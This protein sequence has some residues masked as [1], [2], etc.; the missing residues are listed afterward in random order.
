MF[1]YDKQ[2]RAYHDVKVN[3][4]EAIRDKLKRHRKANQDRIIESKPDG[5]SVSRSRFIKQGSYAMWTTIQEKDNAYDIDDGLVL[6]AD[7]LV[8]GNGTD[9]TPREAK[10]MVLDAVTDPRFD[11]PPKMMPNCVRAFYAEGHH[12]DIAVYRTYDDDGETVQ[13]IAGE[14]TWRKS[15]PRRI[16]IWFQ[17][18]VEDLNATRPGSGSQLRRMV[19]LLKRF[20]KS[21]TSWDMPNG[22]KL[23]MLAAECFTCCSRD[24]EAFCFLIHGLHA[25]LT[26]SLVVEN[27]ADDEWPRARLT[28]TEQDHNMVVLR[29]KTGEAVGRLSVL[30][31]ADCSLEEARDAWDWVFRS[32]GFLEAHDQDAA[33]ALAVFG[34]AVLIGAGL[35]S[36]S[37]RGVIGSEG[38]PNKP[39]RFYGDD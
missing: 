35:A 27:L 14:G 31:K 34:K 36:T 4:P 2:I 39:H 13:E 11:T 7:E 5:I 33:K 19:R 20:A 10:Q 21:R 24:D 15:D 6:D 23:T 12:V 3:L 38:V 29:D 16:T 18:L 17:D 9:W 37:G 8:K 1:D 26:G 28:K 32:D 25:R 22:L 30:A